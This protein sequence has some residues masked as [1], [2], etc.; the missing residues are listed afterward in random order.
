VDAD[1][2]IV[3]AVLEG[4]LELVGKEMGLERFT[5][6]LLG[7]PVKDSS[8]VAGRPVVVEPDNRET[9]TVYAA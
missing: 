1:V 5:V 2:E 9:L 6:V 7:A 4:L 8:I 3:R